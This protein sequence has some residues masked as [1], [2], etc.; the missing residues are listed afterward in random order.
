MSSRDS[1]QRR[2]SPLRQLELPDDVRPEVRAVLHKAISQDGKTPLKQCNVQLPIDLVDALKAEA[3]RLTGHRRR[4]FSDLLAVCARYG[5]EAYQ[6]GDLT[7]ERQATS[8]AYRL[9]RGDD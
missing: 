6:R 3:H 2:G 7:V 5:W 8:I 9:V 4:G 1:L